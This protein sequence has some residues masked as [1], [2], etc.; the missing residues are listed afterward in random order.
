MCLYIKPKSVTPKRRFAY[1]V[2]TVIDKTKYS[3][4]MRWERLNVI[5]RFGRW[6][7]SN[8]SNKTIGHWEMIQGIR[9]GV[10]V[11]TNKRSAERSSVFRSRAN[12]RIIIKVLVCPEDWIADGQNGDAV[13]MK[14]KPIKPTEPVATELHVFARGANSGPIYIRKAKVSR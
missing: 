10:H 12:E 14:V 6:F 4:Y 11:Y 2:V 1:K 13:Y 8:R 5:Y 3:P 7:I 9:N